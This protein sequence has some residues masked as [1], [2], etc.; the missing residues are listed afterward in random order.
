MNEPNFLCL[1]PFRDGYDVAV[2]RLGTLLRTAAGDLKRAGDD[3][4]LAEFEKMDDAEKFV[5]ALRSFD[6]RASA[7]GRV[8]RAF[9]NDAS[10]RAAFLRAVEE[11]AP[12]VLEEA[13]RIAR[14]EEIFADI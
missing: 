4:T 12:R 11:H 10:G 1:Y 13:Q 2:M 7:T 8:F 6:K 5:F 9:S 14:D 3:K